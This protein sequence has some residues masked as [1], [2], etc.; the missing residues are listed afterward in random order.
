MTSAFRQPCPRR[1]LV[2][3]TARKGSE[4]TRNTARNRARLTPV[5]SSILLPSASG[6]LLLLAVGQAG[7][8]RQHGQARCLGQPRGSAS[9]RK[10]FPSPEL[11]CLVE[12]RGSGRTRNFV[13]NEARLTPSGVR[14]PAP[15]PS[16]GPV[17]GP[18]RLRSLYDQRCPRPQV[19][20]NRRPRY[21]IR[22]SR[23]GGL[24]VGARRDAAVVQQ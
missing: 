24:R 2:S 18:A 16:A 1:G 5:R 19:R 22:G 4:W 14:V 17:H 12:W 11:R 13:G 15:P 10:A 8:A 21:P 9:P 23:V 20:A 7:S 6:K 3:P